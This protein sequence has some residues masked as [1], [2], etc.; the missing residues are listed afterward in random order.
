MDSLSYSII[1]KLIKKWPALAFINQHTYGI[2]KKY[3]KDKG[4]VTVEYYLNPCDKTLMNMCK[5]GKYIEIFND[6]L[7]WNSMFF[8]TCNRNQIKLV[9]TMLKKHPSNWNWGFRYACESGNIKVVGIMIDRGADNWNWGLFGAC[10]GRNL[11]I[12][13]LMV[14]KGADNWNWGLSGACEGGCMTIVEFMINLGAND[15]NSGLSSACKGSNPNIVEFMITIGADY[16][17]NCGNLK[18]KF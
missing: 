16:C 14:E 15:W 2:Y 10:K 7:K 8:S 5:K 3:I 17:Y 6:K 18:H 4:Y 11:N 9:E 13:T 12:A 1:I